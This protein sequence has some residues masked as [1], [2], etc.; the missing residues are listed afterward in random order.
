M[1]GCEAERIYDDVF[2]E[3]KSEEETTYIVILCLLCHHCLNFQYAIYVII[4]TNL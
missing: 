4:I 3:L 1:P 2:I